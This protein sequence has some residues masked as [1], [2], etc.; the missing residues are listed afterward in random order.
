MTNEFLGKDIKL[1]DNQIQFSVNQDFNFITDEENLAQA[2]SNRLK[3]IVG[4]YY[5]SSYG[6]QL[7]NVLGE[8]RN[9]LLRGQIIGY[10]SEVLN[11]EPRIQRIESINI[12]F[13]ENT[14]ED[15]ELVEIDINVLPIESDTPLN[16]IYPL[17]LS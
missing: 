6:S 3:T 15:R 10:V 12:T 7:N 16:L 14:F 2:I 4:E 17:F 13:P 9:E 1:K 5:I 11:Q 8:K